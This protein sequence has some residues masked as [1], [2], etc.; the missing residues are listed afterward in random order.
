MKMKIITAKDKFDYAVWS[1]LNEMEENRLLHNSSEIIDHMVDIDISNLA[2]THFY[3][4]AKYLKDNMVLEEVGDPDVYESEMRGTPEYKVFNIFHYKLLDLFNDFYKKYTNLVNGEQDVS[5]FF[6]F[7][8]M[9]FW[10]KLVDG[11]KATI[12]FSPK[13]N[14]KYPTQ[15][16][17]LFRA[18]IQLLRYGKWIRK[19]NWIEIAVT[20]NQIIDEVKKLHLNKSEAIS[21]VWVT[22]A[23]NNFINKSLPSNFQ[24]LIR[25]SSY[26]I[27]SESYTFSLKIP[28]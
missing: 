20:Q 11:S 24:N 6:G 8:D 18:L 22:N 23:R 28:S 12:N 17:Y 3:E 16:Y 7:E 10:L 2:K 26:E 5:E 4:V 14:R 9:T 27:K 15:S 1:I 21:S 13:G 19:G 25:L